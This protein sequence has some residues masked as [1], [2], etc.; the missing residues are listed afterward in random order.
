MN[1]KRTNNTRFYFN[2]DMDDNLEWL[3][4]NTENPKSSKGNLTFP[5]HTVNMIEL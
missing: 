1:Q 2:K 3:I 5:T 4:Q